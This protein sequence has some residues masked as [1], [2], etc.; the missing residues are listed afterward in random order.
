MIQ[1][2]RAH[3]ARP[4]FFLAAGIAIGALLA[5]A[6]GGGGAQA[7]TTYTRAWSCPGFG[8]QPLDDNLVFWNVGTRR[9]ASSIGYVTCAVDLPHKAVVT[10]VRF[11]LFQTTDNGL[12]NDCDLVRAGLTTSNVQNAWV[13]ASVPPSQNVGVS[14]LT[15]TTINLATIDN[16]NYAYY[17][18]CQ[19]RGEPTQQEGIYGADITY[20][21]TAANG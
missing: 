10:R 7:V 5:P 8:F 14:R 6:A 20:K 19:L 4:T 9:T 15:D 3:L 21:I 1:H 2:L 13:M 12:V 11:T 18:Q 17:L 16:M